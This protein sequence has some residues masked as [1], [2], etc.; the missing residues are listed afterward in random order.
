MK[1]KQT[2]ILT[3]ILTVLIVA[4]AIFVGYTIFLKQ[5]ENETVSNIQNNAEEDK[6]NQPIIIQPK[7]VQIFKGNDRPVAV[8]IDNVEDA[9][10][11]ARFEQGIFSIRNSCRRWN[12]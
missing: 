9:W 12:N 1:N 8:M 2:L 11:Q 6:E 10:P 4:S 5:K 7:E 3:I